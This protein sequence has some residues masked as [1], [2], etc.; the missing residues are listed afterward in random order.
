MNE[1]KANW[2]FLLLIIVFIG[3]QFLLSAFGIGSYLTL[4]ASMILSEGMI[5]IPSLCFLLL[6]NERMNDTLQF[7]RIK[8]ADVGLLI[9]YTVLLMPLV[10][11]ANVI[12]MLFVENVMVDMSFGLLEQNFFVSFLLTAVMPAFCEEF[13]FR[14]AIYGSYRKKQ[15]GIVPIVLSSLLF[16]LMHLNFNQAPYAFL[17]GVAICLAYEATGSI[18]AGMIMHL[19]I[20]GSSVVS[21]YLLNRISP[22][23]FSMEAIEAEQKALGE[24]GMTIKDSYALMASVLLL[25]AAAG[26]LLAACVLKY[27]AERN[28]RT[29]EFN[30]IFHKQKEKAH[31]CTVPLVIAIGICLVIMIIGV[32]GV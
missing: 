17:I 30:A 29:A 7:H 1:R 19:V 23:G 10:S 2:L 3:I 22:A 16:G 8:I 11:L 32:V 20:N 14:G 31:L 9:L 26:V 24:M 25:V 6:Q 13:A 4:P 12:S 5:L 15:K 18:F 27:I 21:T 28:G